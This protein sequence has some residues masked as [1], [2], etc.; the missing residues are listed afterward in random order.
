MR[1]FTFITGVTTQAS[2]LSALSLVDLT[3][4]EK[5]ASI[6]GFTEADL[7][8]LF[9]DYM[10]EMLEILKT[11]GASP[12]EATITNLKK[13]ITDWYDGYTWDGQT[14]IFDPWSILHAFERNLFGD[15]WSQ[16]GGVPTFLVN[17]VQTG[18]VD[19]N[20]FRVKI[21]IIKSLNRILLGQTLTL[22]PLLFQ[23]GYLTVDKIDKSKIISVFHLRIPNLEVKA[24]IIQLLLSMEPIKQP[25]AAWEKACR[26]VSSL[27]KLDA[28]GFENAFGSF[29]AEFPDS[30]QAPPEAYYHSLFQAALLLADAK[31]DS[32]VFGGIYERVAINQDH[33]KTLVTSQ[34]FK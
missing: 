15:Y 29:L 7:N 1:G 4:D 23:S 10:E 27:I 24:G 20:V 2:I 14:K 6:C 33:R 9:P 8:S 19:F 13:L 5:Y 31:I 25:L 21:S 30:S 11:K 3:L 32:E 17:L 12:P 26:M 34:L 28:E 18:L 22:I 16:T